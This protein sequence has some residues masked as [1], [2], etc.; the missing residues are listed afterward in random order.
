MTNLASPGLCC[1]VGGASSSNA[2]VVSIAAGG[3]ATFTANVA[4]YHQ[5]PV[6]FYMT[7]VADTAKADDSTQWFKIKEI[8][9]TFFS[10][11]SA[12]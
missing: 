8:G 11:G 4:A 12:T 9:P 3:S 1:N 7:K 6:S 10:G 2:T 5:G